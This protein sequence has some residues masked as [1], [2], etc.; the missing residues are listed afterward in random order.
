MPSQLPLDWDR[1]MAPQRLI[2]APTVRA[3]RASGRRSVSIGRA[4]LAYRAALM[5]FGPATDEE[6]ARRLGWRKVSSCCGR[7]G[8]W[9]ERVPK[10]RPAVVAVGRVRVGAATQSLWQW[11]GGPETD[12]VAAEA[13]S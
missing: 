9:N 10:D 13:T 1:P 11:V 12:A 4:M 3:A 6:I 7:R 2:V 8:D 5:T